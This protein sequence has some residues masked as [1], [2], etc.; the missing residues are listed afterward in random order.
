MLT[1]AL[2]SGLSHFAMANRDRTLAMS[3]S[4]PIV[5]PS[6][7]SLRDGHPKRVPAGS[8]RWSRRQK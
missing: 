1:L 6:T 2:D 5:E 7:V 8:W 4:S 3:T